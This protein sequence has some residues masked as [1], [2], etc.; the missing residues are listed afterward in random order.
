MNS[1]VILGA[2]IA[3]AGA[4][5]GQLVTVLLYFFEKRARRHA[6]LRE[7]CELLSDNVIEANKWFNQLPLCYS[8]ADLKK[9][10]PPSE[11]TKAAMLAKL[12]FPALDKPATD[13]CNCLVEYYHYLLDSVLPSEEALPVSVVARAI[14]RDKPHYLRW[15]AKITTLKNVLQDGLAIQAKKHL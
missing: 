15:D 10:P 9:C 6:I 2:K 5:A 12:Y 13:Y 1:D 3:L 11:T 7:K 4:L 8:F 14:G